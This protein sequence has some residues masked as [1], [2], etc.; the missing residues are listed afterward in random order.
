MNECKK[1]HK[2]AR[3]M[4]IMSSSDWQTDRF[5]LKIAEPK[6]K[7]DIQSIKTQRMLLLRR[8]EKKRERERIK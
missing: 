4:N 5:L 8:R 7:I 2:S 3:E 1:E 6:I